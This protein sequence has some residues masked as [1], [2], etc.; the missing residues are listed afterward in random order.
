MSDV[1]RKIVD[2]LVLHHAVSPTWENKS[3]AELAQW[4]SDN[5]FAR[6]YGSNPANWSGL[7]NPYTNAKSYSQAHYAGQRVDSTTPD[8]TDAERT[9]GFR[10]IQLVK[11]PFGQICW[12]AG[13]WEVNRASIGIECLGDYRNYTLRDGDCRV[14]ADFWRPQD[15]KLG[16]ATAVCGH[17]EVGDNPTACPAR[18]MEMRQ[19]IVDYI[20]N[21]PKP[22]AVITVKEETTT[23]R[24]HFTVVEKEDPTLPDGEVKIETQG[25]DGVV[26]VITTV[27]YTDGVETSRVTKSRLITTQP[28]EQVVLKGAMKPEPPTPP[29]SL[30]DEVLKWLLK[31][32][33]WISSWKKG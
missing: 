20:N 29:I 14:I 33:D 28:I 9:A 25:I 31:I 32:K 21:P 12:H 6:A 4:F 26:T 13:N 5:G 30:W 16:G 17:N 18:I 27:T 15:L 7:Y 19:L 3:K 8:A 11:D 1:N 24:I 23:E 22:P 10:L 2:Y